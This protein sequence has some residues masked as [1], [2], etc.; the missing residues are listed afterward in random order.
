[1]IST[2]DIPMILLISFL[3]G[4]LSL[5]NAVVLALIAKA[6]PVNQQKKALKI[7][8]VGAIAF[9]LLAI[10]AAVYL[11]K[12]R[13]IRI[14]GGAY[15]L[16]LSVSFARRQKKKR[17][18][19]RVTPT[20]H[21]F[22]KAVLTIEAMDILFAIDSILAAVAIS[23]K[24]WVIFWGGCL[25]IIAMRFA[26]SL[27]IRLLRKFPN[28]ERTGHILIFIVGVKLLVESLQLKKI[29]FETP[30]SPA[31]WGFWTLVVLS[32]IF[33]FWPFKKKGKNL[34]RLPSVSV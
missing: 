34:P 29:N 7:G 24:F 13:W 16:Y 19:N 32:L 12:W 21:S 9:R 20:P 2:Q 17:Q 15:L 30:Q 6:L 31:F 28:L 33:G 11:A 3:E 23:N 25:G 18:A 8:M 14:L 26:A 10:S 5:D 27:I 22:W 1:M 4:L